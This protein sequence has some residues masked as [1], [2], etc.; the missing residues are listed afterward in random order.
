MQKVVITSSLFSGYSTIIDANEDQDQEKETIPSDYNYDFPI[1]MSSLPTELKYEI[2]ERVILKSIKSGEMKRCLSILLN[3]NYDF[4]KL[5]YSK[6]IGNVVLTRSQY[7]EHIIGLFE[8]L[9]NVAKCM[10]EEEVTTTEV[11]SLAVF[12]RNPV[13]I[14]IHSIDKRWPFT[15]ISYSIPE[16]PFVITNHEDIKLVRTGPNFCDLAWVA[17]IERNGVVHASYLRAPV[18]ILDFYTRYNRTDMPIW[19][20]KTFFLKNVVLLLKL[21]LGPKSGVYVSTPVDGFFN[22]ITEV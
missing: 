19:R 13:S 15:Q 14:D 1:N 21:C 4:C 16:N 12:C 2:L 6:Y 22:L 8:F 3:S 9:E 17:G 18:L 20:R 10:Y 7:I 11:L 5:F